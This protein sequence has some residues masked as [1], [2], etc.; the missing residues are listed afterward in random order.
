LTIGH[1]GWRLPAAV[2]HSAA[3][4]WLREVPAV[5]ILRRAWMQNYCW[6]GTQLYWREAD[7]IPP[8]APSISS[9]LT[10]GTGRTSAAHP[11]HRPYARVHLGHILTAVELPVL[12]LGEWLLATA[13]AK[14]RITPFAQLLANAAAA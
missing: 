3:P 10:K 4:P 11:L 14:P 1:D 7:N 9:P 13:Q 2:D 12:R 6:D 5:A 8:A